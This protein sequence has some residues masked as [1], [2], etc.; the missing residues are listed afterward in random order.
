MD[1][2]CVIIMNTQIECFR[3]FTKIALKNKIIKIVDIWQHI[4]QSYYTLKKWH[5]NHK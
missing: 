4:I 2:P 1:M 5:G 3:F